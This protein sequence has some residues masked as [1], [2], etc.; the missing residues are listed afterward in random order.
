MHVCCRWLTHKIWCNTFWFMWHVSPLSHITHN[1]SLHHLCK[2]QIPTLLEKLPWVIYTPQKSNIDTKNDALENA[3]PA[4]NMPSFCV[5]GCS[6][7]GGGGV[8]ITSYNSV[9][10]TRL[11][12]LVF[13][14]RRISIECSNAEFPKIQGTQGTSA[15]T[16]PHKSAVTTLRR[17]DVWR[18][19][20]LLPA[21]VAI[22]HLLVL[23]LPSGWLRDID[24]NRSWCS[25]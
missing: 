21:S 17:C 19:P 10:K 15:A 3:S 16:R 11:C 14:F 22:F 1:C 20:Q 9:W 18:K 5:S 7:S 4:S 12:R 23:K 13:N 25:W 8:I 24:T 2:L 6:I